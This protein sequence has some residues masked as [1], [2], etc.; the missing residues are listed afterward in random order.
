MLWNCFS[1]KIKWRSAIPQHL[2]SQVK[3]KEEDVKN[4]FKMRQ[5]GN[6][7]VQIAKFYNIHKNHV[8]AILTGKLWKHLGL[9]NK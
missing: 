7:N 5:D 6:T 8:S 1:H 3:L 2:Q 9:V 4:I